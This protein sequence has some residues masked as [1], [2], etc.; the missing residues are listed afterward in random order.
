M[1]EEIVREASLKEGV[2]KETV[3]V[4]KDVLLVVRSIGGEK[5]I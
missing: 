2:R 5:K 1:G 4:S 3:V